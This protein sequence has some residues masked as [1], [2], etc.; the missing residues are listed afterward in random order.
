MRKSLIAILCIVLVLLAVL[1]SYV[2]VKT[3]PKAEKKQPP[4]MAAL[5]ETLPLQKTDETVVLHQN[6]T[7]G[8]AVEALIQAQV[9]GK[10]VS[11][12]DGFIDG[13]LLAKDETM[14]RIEAIDYELAI[15]A[16]AAQLEKARADYKLE[17]GRQDV[18]RREWELLKS[19]DASETE[20]ELALRQPQLAASK[21]ALGAAESALENARLDLARTEVRAPFNAIVLARNV[22]MG[23]QATLQGALARL[24]GT[25][26]Y[27]VT[28]S[29]PVDR[30]EWIQIP[31]SPARIVSNGGSVREG[32]VVRLLGDLEM[33]G[34]MARVLVEVADPLCLKPE[35]AGKKPL[36]IGEYVKAEIDGRTLQ[37]VFRIPRNALREDGFVWLAKEGKLDIRPVEVLWRDAGQVLVRDGMEI[38][39]RLVVSDLNAPIQG[40]DVK[41]AGHKE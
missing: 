8:P 7:V 2:L 37:G 39:E 12:D 30:L 5:V 6:G 41:P 28:V 26:A 29:V 32:R 34:R 20:Q 10:I 27:W 3:A 11:V 19:G 16:A 38:G 4:K 14:L 15:A 31:G 36:L 24:A 40:M 22:N 17:L 35:N 25:D 9:V 1:G 13:G 18:A 21:A 33:A 23:S